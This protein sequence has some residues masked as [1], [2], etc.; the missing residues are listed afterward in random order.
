MKMKMKRFCMMILAVMCM[1]TVL[2]G[3]GK[4]APLDGTW[5]V[6][7][8][9]EDKI[10][11]GQLNAVLRYQQASYYDYQQQMIKQYE[12]MSQQGMQFQI[13][14]EIFDAEATNTKTVSDEERMFIPEPVKAKTTGDLLLNQC[15]TGLVEY[16]VVGQHAEEYQQKF[17]DDEVKKMKEA[18]ASYYKKNQDVLKRA[19]VT[20]EDVRKYLED[21]TM[22]QKMFHKIRGDVHPNIKKKD[23]RLMDC[24]VI[25]F[26]EGEK[27]DGKASAQKV[28]DALK[29]RDDIASLNMSTM[30]SDYLD[31]TA[32]DYTF[33]VNREEA[34]YNIDLATLKKISELKAG[35]LYPEVVADS[36]GNY[37]IFRMTNP[38][39]TEQKASFKETLI[40]TEKDKVYKDKV[41]E[42]V[43]ALKIRYNK[44]GLSAVAVT[45]KSIY[46]F[47]EKEK[48]SEVQADST[49]Q[50]EVKDTGA[51]ESSS[52]SS[53][54]KSE[55]NTV[56]K[57]S[58]KK[59]K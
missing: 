23:L 28:L 13:P 16:R 31:A 22:Y 12:Q 2:A 19:G 30:I 15:L 37:Y 35:E 54:E 38:K 6:A 59:E 7:D 33:S 34:A 10:T 4:E 32:A 5:L 18:S 1:I 53:K 20:E 43:K 8:V 57:D 58:S 27:K 41:S 36:E 46:K 17:S 51:E 29:Q 48:S 25:M 14:D 56:E 26:P 39:N 24:S 50:I 3:C 55:T 49:D 40:N 21:F 9:G 44:K 47:A 45:D 52:E 11:L 42:W